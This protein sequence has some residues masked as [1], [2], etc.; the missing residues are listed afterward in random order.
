MLKQLAFLIPLFLFYCCAPFCHS[1]TDLRNLAYYSGENIAEVAGVRSRIAGPLH[2]FRIPAISADTT[3]AEPEPFRVLVFHKTNGFR[4]NSIEAGIRMI[5]RLGAENGRWT[6][7]NTNVGAAF[8]LQNLARYHVVI[9]CNTSGDELLDAE[10][11]A[12]FEAFIRGGGGFVGIHA[13]ADTYRDRNWPWYNDLVGGI[14]RANP[15][16]TNAN[17]VADIDVVG[18]HPATKHLGAVWNKREEYYYWEGNGGYLYPGNVELLRV[19]A[20][21]EASHD[22]PRPIAWYKD[23]D[24]GRAFY[25]ALGH[26]VN[27]YINDTDFIEHIE[28]AILWAAGEMNAPMPKPLQQALIRINCGGPELRFD[29][30][31]FTQD[32]NFSPNTI[33]YTNKRVDSV[34]A[35]R[36][37]D[38]YLTERVSA[39][40]LHPFQYRFRLPNGKYQVVLHFAEIF[41]GAPGGGPGGAKRRVFSVT[42]QGEPVLVDFD[43]NAETGPLQAVV[44]AYITEVRDDTLKLDFSASINRPKIAAIEIFGLED[45]PEEEEPPAAEDPCAWNALA[46][47]RLSKIEAQSVKLNGKMYV[48]AGFLAGLR[49]TPETEIYDPQADEWT[50]GAPM[51]LAVTHMGAAAVGDEIWIV[52]GFVGNHPGPATERV[53]IYNTLTDTWREGPPLPQRRASGAAV[54]HDG[55]VHYFG[56]LLPDRRTD[57][58]EHYVFHLNNPEAGWTEATPMPEPRNHLSGVV[59]NGKI[60]A[61][62]GQFGHDGQVRD[63]SFLHVY[64]PDTDAWERKADLPTPRSHFEPGTI[65]HNDKIIIVGGRNGGRFFETITEYDPEMDTWSE[66]CELPER[67]LAPAAKVFGDRLIVANGG[68]DG[69]CCPKPTTRWIR[70]EP[71]NEPS[72][73]TSFRQPPNA[74]KPFS[75]NLTQHGAFPNPLTDQLVL[76]YRLQQQAPVHLAVF[77]AQGVQMYAEVIPANGETYQEVRIN[78]HRWPPGIFVYRL[79]VGEEE[80]SGKLIRQP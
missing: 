56:G 43:I 13:A 58:G 65:M 69:T 31:V 40:N 61:I 59:I 33:T 4:H 34:S 45:E 67:L 52:G 12:A 36:W 74:R 80:I 10:Q 66:L 23:Y 2:S 29:S 79:R 30:V 64:D 18:E 70:V 44:R 38:L 63:Q 68:M 22:A 11:R 6:T 14:V 7:D 42:L 49:I 26:H 54:Y 48:F 75:P 19:R 60:Y 17:V 20:T 62:G 55:K 39:Q 27:D 37:N 73:P 15:S 24:G 47:S 72:L 3:P 9:W 21:G 25:T 77:D 76:F 35:P 32:A 8:N 16:H 53:Q 51:P 57:V 5:E 46:D 78:T 28:G 50:S 1:Q 41:F 71:E